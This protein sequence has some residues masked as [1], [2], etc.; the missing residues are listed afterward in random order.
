MTVVAEG[1]ETA[2]VHQA[3]AEAWCDTIQGYHTGR[4]MSADA[5]EDW[6]VVRS[7]AAAT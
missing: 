5:L 6:I 3:L 4:P 1:V 2:D 7:V